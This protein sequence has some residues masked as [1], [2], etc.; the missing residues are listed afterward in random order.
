MEKAKAPQ[1][2]WDRGVPVWRATRAAIK[3]GFPTTRV[4]LSFFGNDEAAL[5]ARC[6]RL[7]AE[8]NEWLSGSRDRDIAFN[9]TIRAVIN[10]WQIDKDSPYH[11]IEASSRHPYDVYARMIVETVGERRVDAVDGRDLRRWHA[12][13]SAPLEDG[14]KPRLAAARMAVIVLKN[15]LTFAATCR[16]PGCAELRGILSQIRF[17]GPRSRT[18]AP[19]AAEMVAARKAAHGIDHSAAALAYALQFEGAMRQWDVVGKWV[20]LT[21]KRPSSVIDGT[22]KWIGPMWSQIHDMIFQYT[23]AKTQFTSGAKVTLDLRMLPMVV[24]ELSKV[25][26]EARRGPLIVNPRTGLPYRNSYYGHVWDKVRKIT[27]IKPEVWNRDIR[28]AA[29]TEGRQAGS[30]TDDLAKT[31]GHANKR[32]TAK[33]YDRDRLEAARRVAQARV[34]YRGKNTE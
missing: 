32:T 8:M 30:P 24:E 19:T 2:V 14:G 15:A 7:T 21:D 28:A 3:A 20:P 11:L 29:V 9:G 10:F 26:E 34:A 31:A 6:H 13:W 25:P 27:G 17:A 4:N 23:P 5:I 12:E 22:S 16:K 18:E 33:V 1:L